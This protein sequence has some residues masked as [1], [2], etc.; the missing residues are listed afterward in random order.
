[1]AALGAAQGFFLTAILLG[2]KSGMPASNRLF[3]LLV[4]VISLGILGVALR[5][6]LPPFVSAATER[7]HEPFQFLIGPLMLL[8]VRSLMTDVPFALRRDWPHSIAFFVCTVLSAFGA[9]TGV[10]VP[11]PVFEAATQF[12]V[13]CYL[14][15]AFAVECRAARDSRVP[16]ANARLSLRLIAGTAVL[17][18]VF[19][20]ILVAVCALDLPFA[21]NDLAAGAIGAVSLYFLA[22]LYHALTPTVMPLSAKYR[23]SPLDVKRKEDIRRALLALLRDGRAFIDPELSLASV[24]GRLGVPRQY[25]SQV[26]GE[27]E[28]DTFSG[29]V[30]RLRLDEFARRVELGDQR[31]FTILALAL[32]SGFNSKTAFNVAFRKRFGQTPAEYVKSAEKAVPSGQTE[33]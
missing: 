1:M 11:A 20:V 18:A 16:R 19:L 28:D 12:H 27:L 3:A 17:Y 4:S 33:R 23:Q 9:A 31:R 22:Y 8:T 29:L 10:A 13:W 14:A 7:M 25:L 5:S 32:D 26:I 15:V 24:S 2:T 30:N 6:A 21:V